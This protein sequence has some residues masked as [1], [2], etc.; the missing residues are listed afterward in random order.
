MY[1]SKCSYNNP[2]SAK[3]CKNCEVDLEQGSAPFQRLTNST[4]AYPIEAEPNVM[5][6]AGFWVRLL[7]A[8]L[9]ILVLLAGLILLLVSI[10]GYIAYT[11]R[12]SILHEQF[13]T[14]IFYG[15]IIVMVLA[16]SILMESGA[17]GATLGKRWMN[18]KVMDSMENQLSATQAVI[19][20]IARLLSLAAFGIGFLIQPFTRQKQALHDIVASTVVIYANESRKISIMASLLVLLMAVMVPVLAIL[21]TAGLPVLQQQILKVQ[22]NHGIQSGTQAAL[23][24]ARLYHNTGRVPLSLDDV[25]RNIGASPHIAGIKINPQNGEIT[26]TFSESV[27]KDIRNKHLLFKPA[28]AADQSISWKCYSNDIEARILPATCK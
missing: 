15:A 12:E 3:F 11:G 1:C 13:A 24:V 9:D 6:Y 20:F 28:L 2:V 16:Y 19:R 27:R 22:I 14:T 4:L 5:V 18:I 8:F 21:A 23:A 7:A 17:T 25:S 10:A 26:L